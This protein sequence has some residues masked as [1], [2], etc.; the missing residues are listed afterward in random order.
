MTPTALLSGSFWKA[1]DAPRWAVAV[2][3]DSESPFPFAAA[4]A[5]E[6]P[7]TPVRSREAEKRFVHA[8]WYEFSQQDSRFLLTGSINATRKALTTTD[9]VELG[10]LRS[11]GKNGRPMDWVSAA[12]PV[13]AAQKPLPSGLGSHELAYASFDRTEPDRLSGHLITLQPA[14]GLWQVR[15]VQADGDSVSHDVEVD[16]RGRFAFRDRALESFSQAPA[17]QILM[18]MGNREA[19]GWVHNDMLLGMS[20]RRRL[21]AGA[22][23][24]LMRRDATDD[25]I[26]ALLDYLS[27]HAEQ[28]L[29]LF[30][31]P[32]AGQN[33]RD[34][35]G[36]AR[37]QNRFRAYRRSGSP[38]ACRRRLASSLRSRA[39]AG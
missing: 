7:V 20:A 29:R 8:K 25:D 10:V 26:Q 23:A 36:G 24:R 16:Q 5:W 6:R 27:I 19:R 11:I 4:A 33:G 18:T 17:V 38:R 3:D 15:L 1:I 37:G 13:F 30:N 21:T 32:I 39:C 34:E 9:N 14:A 31:L 22:L 12:V 28:H 35:D 2:T